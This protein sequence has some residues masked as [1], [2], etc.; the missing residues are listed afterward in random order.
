MLFRSLIVLVLLVLDSIEDEALYEYLKQEE[1]ILLVIILLKL[2]G[3]NIK[4]ISNII[5]V[6][7]STIYQKISKIKKNFH[8]F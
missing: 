3:Y 6:P 7:I 8:D 4:E 2:Q 5:K 1:P